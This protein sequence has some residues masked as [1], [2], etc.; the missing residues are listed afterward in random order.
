MFERLRRLQF[1]D[2]LDALAEPGQ[3]VGDVISLVIPGGSTAYRLQLSAAF[4]G[5]V[6]VALLVAIMRRLDVA[7]TAAIASGLGFAFHQQTWLHAVIPDSRMGSMPV[8]ALSVLVL[9]LWSETRKAGLLWSGLGCWLLSFAANPSLL[10]TAPVLVWFVC[11]APLRESSGALLAA[12]VTGKALRV[13]VFLA[14]TAAGVVVTGEFNALR[15]YDVLS[16]EFGLLGFLVL[17]LGLAHYLW[18]RPTPQTLLLSL[19]LAGVVGGLS[20]SAATGAQ[21]LPVAL[22]FACPI[23]GHGLSVIVRSR[24]DRTHA[25]TATAVFLVFPTINLISHRDPIEAARDDHARSVRHA[26]ALAA[27]L[28]DGGAV[29]TFPSTREP[30]PPLWPLSQ[31]GRLQIVDLPWGYSPYRGHRGKP[32]DLRSGSDPDT[33]GVSRIPVRRT[34]SCPYCDFTERLSGTA[35]AGNDRRHGREC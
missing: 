27:L 25:A 18:L 1:R 21:Q 32:T 6:T 3:V 4:F 23:V 24:T 16:S 30:L 2:V 20:V 9:L 13:G 14:V 29:A 19:S 33:S 5:A 34:P 12:T 22:L 28:P 8:L 31:S 7:C 15:V 26:R 17:S 10:C 35:G 11:K